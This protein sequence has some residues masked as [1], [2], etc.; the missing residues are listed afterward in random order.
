M[1]EQAKSKTKIAILLTDGHNTPDTE[2]PFQAA[3]D[4]ANKQGIKVYPIGIGGS[5]EYNEKT[6]KRIAKQT[7]GVSFGAS[8][9]DELSEV[10]AKINELEKSEIDNETFNFLRYYFSFPLSLSLLSLMLYVFLRNRSKV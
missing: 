9:A 4:L 8:N 6:L 10:Y 3:I 2:F 5:G 7:G 1:T